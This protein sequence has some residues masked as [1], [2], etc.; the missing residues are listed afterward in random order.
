MKVLCS[1][2][3]ALQRPGRAPDKHRLPAGLRTR[4]PLL[5]RRDSFEVPVKDAVQLEDVVVH[6]GQVGIAE[7]RDESK[8]LDVRRAEREK[9]PEG[10]VDANVQ[11]RYQREATR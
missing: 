10:I 6:K 4:E 5:I 8:Q 7:L 2:A 1:V 11:T 3:L 9:Q